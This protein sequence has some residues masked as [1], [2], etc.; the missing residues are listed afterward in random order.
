MEVTA[1]Q[2]KLLTV[3]ADLELTS[4]G[5]RWDVEDLCRRVGLDFKTEGTEVIMDLASLEEGV[6]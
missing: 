4:P 3:L 6:S 5:G 2:Q 1:E